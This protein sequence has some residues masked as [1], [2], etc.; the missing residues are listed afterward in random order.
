MPSNPVDG[1][2]STALDGCYH[3]PSGWLLRVATARVYDGPVSCEVRL[4]CTALA[5]CNHVRANSLE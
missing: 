1:R 4:W 5:A 2:R 3:C